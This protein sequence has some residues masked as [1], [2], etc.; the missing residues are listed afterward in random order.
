MKKTA[1]LLALLM[2][3]SAVLSACGGTD[4]PSSAQVSVPDTQSEVSELSEPVS[5]PVSIP[6]SDTSEEA[7]KDT[8]EESAEPPEEYTYA[9]VVSRGKSYKASQKPGASYPDSYGCEL[10]DGLF[11]VTESPT[12]TDEKLVGY[13]ETVMIDVDL[14][15]IAEKLYRFEVSFLAT[16]TAGIAPPASVRISISDDGSE[17]TQVGRC[18]FEKHVEDTIQVCYLELEHSVAARY[19]RFEVRRG[20]HWIFLDEV[21]VIAD[22]EG[23]DSAQIWEDSIN[24]V[25]IN[26]TL[27]A[28]ER[29]AALEK[30]SVS[31]ADRTQEAHNVANNCKYTSSAKVDKVYPD[32]GRLTD[33]TVSGYYES[34]CWVGYACDGG[35]VEITVDLGK[36][37]TDI[38]AFELYAYNNKTVGISFP[39]CVTYSVSSDKNEWTEIGRVYSPVKED[40]THTYLLRL[41]TTVRAR[42]VRFT[43]SDAGYKLFLVE[44]IRVIAYSN[45]IKEPAL[46]PEVVFP[47]VDLN[48]VWPADSENYDTES[49]LLR[50]LAQQISCDNE[51]EKSAW[52]NNTPVTSKLLTDGRYAS[53]TDIHNGFFFK[54][55]RPGTRD[56]FYDLGHV[57][58]LSSFTAEFTHQTDWAVDC[59]EK[60]KIMLSEDAKTWYFAGEIVMPVMSDPSLVRGTL[61]LEKAVQARF[62]CFEFSVKQWAGCDE[63]EAKGIKNTA[64]A[65]PLSE[66]GFSSG[67]G[68]MTNSY[69]APSDDLLGGAKDIYLAYH[70]KNVERTVEDLL[71]ALAYLDVNGEPQDVMFDGFLF[72]LTGTFPSGNAGHEAYTANDV[73]WLMETLFADGKN[74]MALEEAAGIVKQKLGLPESYKYKYYVT[75]YDFGAGLANAGDIDGD[76]VNENQSVFADRVKFTEEVIKKYEQ[77]M[78]EHQFR[79]IEFCGYYWYDE[80]MDD[81]HGDMELL[82]AV[83]DLVHKHNSQFFWIPWFKAYGYSLWKE[84]GFDAACMQPNYMFKLEAPFSNVKECATLTKR[85]G[86][87]VEIEFCSAAMT[88]SRYRTRYLQYLSSGV[89]EGFM[90]DVIH[91]YY[92]ETTSFIWLYK[93]EY[94]PNRVMYDYTYQFIKGTLDIYPD[95]LPA[96]SFETASGTVLKSKLAENPEEKLMFT[97]GSSPAHGTVTIDSDGSFTYYPDKDYKGEDTFSFRYSELLEYSEPCV[98][99]VTVN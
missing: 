48:D 24:A 36:E 42:Y 5:E 87:C 81:A 6:V 63:L 15:E 3:I 76:G 47:E 7:S 84:H 82:N 58:A 78:A 22:V 17:W 79:N 35:D 80:S 60:V 37:R 61:T 40:E 26:E 59:P 18:R 27:T 8:S 41:E 67:S 28:S 57:S 49:N 73:K 51:P 14:G 45:D 55:N 9:T 96:Q 29:T 62:V 10:T 52:S 34:G 64:D 2:L 30:V 68:L 46:Y 72:L 74:I 83:S 86:M 12:Y 56:I 38:S 23:E 91:M 33:N 4:E 21:S 85:Y 1:L 16:H 53:G 77:A 92:L 11:A 69:L 66:S 71:P 32:E 94:Y 50:G 65:I 90:K 88:D 98:V 93:S 70:G 43:L 31:P 39:L 20:S 95:T 13:E 44:E 19:I 75:L 25:Y 99:T 89:T 97:I 54:F